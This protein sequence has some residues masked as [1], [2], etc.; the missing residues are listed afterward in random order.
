MSGI[1]SETPVALVTGASYG[2]G[3][4]T[5]V[6][7]ARDG[8]DLAICDLSTDMLAEAAEAIGRLGRRVDKIT[9]DLRD[10]ASIA[11]AT[12]TAL[13]SFGRIDVLVNNAGIPFRKPALEVTRDD[14]H[15]VMDVNLAGTFFMSQRVGAHWIAAKRPGAIISVAS[16]HGIHGVPGSSTYGIA[17]AGIS[18]MTRMLAIEWAPHRIRVN[19]I[20]P[21]STETPTRTGLS[22]PARRDAL[23]SRFPL[24][25]FGKPEDMAEAVAYLAG[26]KA[27]FITGHVLVI[28]GGLT[29]K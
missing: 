23:L 27:D 11:V 8:F 4:A 28:D 16:T 14:F 17:K 19:A 15:R 7:L 2:I 20:A 12:E 24:G 5:A 25:R 26:P 21:G 13:D 3:A 9:L 22:D 6:A 1:D 29:A 10:D 18:H